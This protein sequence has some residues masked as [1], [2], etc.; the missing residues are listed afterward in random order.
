MGSPFLGHD[1]NPPFTI[2]EQ[3]NN[4]VSTFGKLKN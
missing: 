3:L 1:D 4:I 2:V